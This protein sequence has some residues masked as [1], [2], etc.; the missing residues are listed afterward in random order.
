MEWLRESKTIVER[1]G[2]RNVRLLSAV[3][4]GEATGMIAFI[5][6]VDDFAANGAMSDGFM[7]DPEAASKMASSFGSIA[8]HQTA[9][10][11]DVPL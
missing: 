1:F 9:L 3:V 7:S 5:T 6:E 2:A 11:V 4:A 10:W 8:G